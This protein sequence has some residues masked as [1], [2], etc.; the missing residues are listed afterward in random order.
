[1][2]TAGPIPEHTHL[3]DPATLVAV[4]RAAHAIGDRGLERTARQAL[5]DQHGIEITF[6]RF[7]KGPHH[8]DQS[9]RDR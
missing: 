5:R 1:M 2:K 4:A 3:S 9:S 8:G 6:H 7:K